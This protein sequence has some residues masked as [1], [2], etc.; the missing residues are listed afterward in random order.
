MALVTRDAVIFDAGEPVGRRPL[1]QVPSL[2][3]DLLVVGA[4]ETNQKRSHRSD[5]CRVASEVWGSLER[6]RAPSND[7]NVSIEETT[8]TVLQIGPN[9]HTE[10]SPRLSTVATSDGSEH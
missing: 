9:R 1:V 4:A 10:R 6:G 8:I 2:P 3:A 5:G 7:T